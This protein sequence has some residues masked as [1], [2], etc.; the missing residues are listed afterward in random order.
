M[1]SQPGAAPRLAGVVVVVVVVALVVLRVVAAVAAA[2]VAGCAAAQRPFGDP[3]TA[4]A[5]P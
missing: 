2:R 1:A 3:D 5:P 4:M